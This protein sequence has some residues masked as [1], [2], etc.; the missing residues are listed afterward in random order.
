MPEEELY[1][2]VLPGGVT[3]CKGDLVRLIHSDKAGPVM[4]TPEGEI[5]LLMNGVYRVKSIVER[6]RNYRGGKG[7]KFYL[8]VKQTGEGSIRID[9]FVKGKVYFSDG[10][11]WIPY[12]VRVVKKASTFNRS[13]RHGKKNRRKNERGESDEKENPGAPNGPG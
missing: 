9:A 10:I 1:K 3:V 4:N 8:E 11:S 2:V 12:E 13:K 6:W 5:P 7:S